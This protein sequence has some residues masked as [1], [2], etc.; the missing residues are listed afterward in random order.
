MMERALILLGGMLLCS[1]VA[2][3]QDKFF[4]DDAELAADCGREGVPATIRAPSDRP[5]RPGPLITV[6]LCHD[7]DTAERILNYLKLNN[8]LKWRSQ[9]G[10]YSYSRGTLGC[11]N[12]FDARVENI[13]CAVLGRPL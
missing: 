5:D 9:N 6:V 3:A 11:W 4:A 12:W 8:A 1:N 10:E 2:D 7:R 13:A